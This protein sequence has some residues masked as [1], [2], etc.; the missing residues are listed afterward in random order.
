MYIMFVYIAIHVC[1]ITFYSI[2]AD[3]QKIAKKLSSSITKETKKAKQL[4][5]AYI[6]TYAQLDEH[7][8]DVSFADILAVDSSFWQ[9]PLEEGKSS[10]GIP[11]SLK[12]DIVQSYLL[13]K[14]STEEL[15]L[16]KSSLKN[17]L[18][19][20][21]LKIHRIEMYVKKLDNA[22][23]TSDYTQYEMGAK[24][25]LKQYLS[26]LEDQQAK[27]SRVFRS[28]HAG[29]D[30]IAIDHI[31]DEESDSSSIA[32]DVDFSDDHQLEDFD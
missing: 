16:L 8:N 24:C 29:D 26:S 21:E 13:S 15:A 3:G 31:S 2:P 4:H 22:L 23:A 18:K 19:Y 7:Y 5:Q 14:R 12:R 11:F 1:S 6:S 32:S 30:C 25:S 9:S 27:A 10:Y 17:M 28:M 20:L